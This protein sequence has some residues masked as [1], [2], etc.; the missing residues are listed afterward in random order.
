MPDKVASLGPT[1][2]SAAR[3]SVTALVSVS[4]HDAPA[5]LVGVLGV[6]GALGVPA[7]DCGVPGAC[8][9]SC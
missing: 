4:F 9:A 3:A 2:H 6:L 1:K 8:S 7:A 5:V